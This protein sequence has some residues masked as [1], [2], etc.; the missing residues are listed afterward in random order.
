[1]KNTWV[2]GAVGLA[3]VGVGIGVFSLSVSA[4]SDQDRPRP[5]MPETVDIE[6][7]AVLYAQSCAACHG[8]QLEGQ[9]D[10]RS[11]GADGLLPAPPHDIT[12]HTWHHA[13]RALFE[14]TLLGGR[15]ALAQQGL[16]FESGMPAFGDALSD[17]EIW[18]ILAFIQST[19]PD[20]N[21]EIQAARTEADLAR[22]DY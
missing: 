1:M 10:W 13:D 9:P 17:A 2:I 5:V 11:P 4:E 7:G 20:R 12:G 22:G 8:T 14:Y 15:E 16:D 18:N 21:R 19:W 3:L 6:Q